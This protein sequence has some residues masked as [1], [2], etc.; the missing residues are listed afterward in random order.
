MIDLLIYRNVQKNLFSGINLNTV[1]G[2]VRL[3]R[4]DE[5]LAQ[6]MNLSPEEI[7]MR[8][9]NYHMEQAGVDRRITNFTND[10]K[11]SFIYTHLIDQIAP[12]GS[13]GCID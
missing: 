4:G 3:L 7:L 9:V 12:E 2:L 1:P 10:I 6:L 11:D 13:G 8:W 5:T